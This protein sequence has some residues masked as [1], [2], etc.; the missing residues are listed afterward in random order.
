MQK[1]TADGQF[2]KQWYD[3]PPEPNRPHLSASVGRK[4]KKRFAPFRLRSG[5]QN[6]RFSAG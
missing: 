1:I 5:F 6:V 4:T 3:F 2:I